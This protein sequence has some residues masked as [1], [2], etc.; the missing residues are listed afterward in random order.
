MGLDGESQSG[1]GTDFWG[2]G[3]LWSTGSAAAE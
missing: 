3:A 1:L 2:N